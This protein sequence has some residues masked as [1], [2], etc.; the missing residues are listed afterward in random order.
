MFYQVIHGFLGAGV[1]AQVFRHATYC[2]QSTVG[3][4]GRY[5]PAIRE[6][7]LLSDLGPFKEIIEQ[8][9]LAL[10]PVLIEQF[11]LSPFTANGVETQI[12]ADGEAAFYGLH[13]DF[14]TGQDRENA[15]HIIGLV[16]SFYKEPKAF[17]G[18]VLRLYPGIASAL[19]E[20]TIDIVPAQ[21]MAVAFSSWMPH[22][23]MQVSCP[24]GDFDDFCFAINCWVLR[25]KNVQ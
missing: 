3:A 23:V 5:D 16:Y 10:V 8:S 14:F 25:A 19:D 24:S 22:E 20:P 21:D 2:K 7:C 17:T 6:S 4:T 15:D 9:V 12:A 18:G 13:I 1:N 11:G